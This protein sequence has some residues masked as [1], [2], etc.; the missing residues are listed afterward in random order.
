MIQDKNAR[1]KLN[2]DTDNMHIVRDSKGQ[3]E[4]GNSND[5]GTEII[6]PASAV[7]LTQLLPPPPTPPQLEWKGGG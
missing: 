4:V 6:Y 1:N 7:G 5:E 3:R 2:F